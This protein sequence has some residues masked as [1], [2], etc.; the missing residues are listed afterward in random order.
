[1]KASGLVIDD[2]ALLKIDIEGSEGPLSSAL[3]EMLGQ[4]DASL[5]PSILLSVHTPLWPAAKEADFK[6][7]VYSV[8]RLYSYVYDETLR[9][10]DYSTITP[11]V[12]AGNTMFIMTNTDLGGAF[13]RAERQRAPDYSHHEPTGLPV[14]YA[15]PRRGLT[16]NIVDSTQYGRLWHHLARSDIAAAEVE[17]LAQLIDRARAA[18]GIKAPVG[19]TA[20]KENGSDDVELPSTLADA[21]AVRP[22]GAPVPTPA[23]PPPRLVV[24]DVG[25]GVGFASLF[26]ARAGATKVVAI[27]PDP[28]RFEELRRN[29]ASSNLTSTVT[30]IKTCISRTGGQ[31]DIWPPLV[32]DSDEM[33]MADGIGSNNTVKGACVTL[34]SALASAGVAATD[35]SVMII[36]VLGAESALIASLRQL[37]AGQPGMAPPFP[38]ILRIYPHLWPSQR[39]RSTRAL[40]GS[41]LSQFAFVVDERLR[42]VNVRDTTAPDGGG[43]VLEA[44]DMYV[45]SPWRIADIEEVDIYGLPQ[46]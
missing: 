13:L 30:A 14:Q 16:A 10:L 9:L 11:E 2:I 5:R 25:A 18:A 32:W 36:D 33:H 40:I 38:I 15:F 6:R 3:A 35:V 12:V 20:A 27:E 17:A 44:S 7:G 37:L 19:N 29:V 39:A 28:G 21:A 8:L 46:P 4:V 1:M 45:A 26:A 31:T 22:P 42:A 43:F 34:Q 41:F 23:P 24:V